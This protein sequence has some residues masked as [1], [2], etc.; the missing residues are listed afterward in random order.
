MSLTSA[1][2]SSS[3][4][5]ARVRFTEGR[6]S[7]GNQSGYKDRKRQVSEWY[8]ELRKVFVLYDGRY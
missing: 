3:R 5:R 4:E 2:L 1:D 8:V 7:C 6:G